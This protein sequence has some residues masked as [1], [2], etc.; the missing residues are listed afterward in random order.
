MKHRVLIMT[1]LT[2]LFI[3]VWILGSEATVESISSSLVRLHIVANSDSESDQA[4]K[5]AVRDA[6]LAYVSEL[7][8]ECS[9]EVFNKNLNA[10]T[11]IAETVL[12]KH[13]KDYKCKISFEK[14]YFPTKQY[15]NI[16]L[17]A[18]EYDAVR[19][20]LGNAKGEN[21]W[22]VMSPPLCFTNETRGEIKTED[23]R[24]LEEVMGKEHYA[25]IHEE[26]NI[27]IKPEFKLVEWWQ[28]LKHAICG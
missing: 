1:L 9:K 10:I 26:S 5:L 11:K 2:L 24:K 13:H 19:I 3:F 27:K 21:W 23:L 20:L 28:E 4:A 12:A 22:C 25:L 18:G 8:V 16:I 6:V 7:N 14:C 17:P 15:K